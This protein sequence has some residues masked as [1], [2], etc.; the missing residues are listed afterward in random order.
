MFSRT[1]PLI[2]PMVT[3]AGSRVMSTWR[4][5]TVCRPST[6]C[7]AVTI[8]STPSHGIAPCVC[9]PSTLMLKRV[10]ARHR[11]ARAVAEHA[12]R[13][14]RGDVQAEDRLRHRV[15]ERALG[16]H[17]LRAA[18]LA[19]GRQLLGRLEDELDRAAQLRRAGR[20]APRPRPSGWRRGQSWPQ[21]CMTPTDLAVPLRLHLRGERHVDLLGSTGSASMSARSATTGPG[22]APFSRPTTPVWA[23]PVRTSSRPSC[24]RCS[25]TMPAVRNSRL[26]SSGLAW[27]SRRQA[28]TRRLD[29]LGGG[30]DLCRRATRRR[31]GLRTWNLL[32]ESLASLGRPPA[33]GRCRGGAGLDAF[34][35]RRRSGKI[36]PWIRSPR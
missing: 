5:T 35:L 34:C 19:L 30:I 20:R 36:E 17:H 9:R 15:L 27:M 7:A 13:Q 4:L 12:E 3:T 8:G 29:C 10:G 18:L 24:F 14:P 22:S 2:M 16:D 23:T 31:R 6:T 21:A 25:A 33:D 26:P 28:I 1:P 11:R 32:D